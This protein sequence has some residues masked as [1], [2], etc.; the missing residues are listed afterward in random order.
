MIVSLL[1]CKVHPD[2]VTIEHIDNIG[3][4]EVGD[5]LYPL[6]NREE[7]VCCLVEDDLILSIHCTM[8]GEVHKNK[9][10]LASR[11]VEPKLLK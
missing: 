2:A 6:L 10:L 7:R 11:K 9:C 4:P 1:F 3:V 8:A 5:N